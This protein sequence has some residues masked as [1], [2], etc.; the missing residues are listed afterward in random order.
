MWG[1]KGK[2]RVIGKKYALSGIEPIP[3]LNERGKG[4]KKNKKRIKK[5]C[6]KKKKLSTESNLVY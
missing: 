5:G 4:K 6:G 1:K 2:K 3:G